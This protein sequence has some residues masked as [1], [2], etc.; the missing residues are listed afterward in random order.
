MPDPFD[1]QKK[2]PPPI[3]IPPLLRDNPAAHAHRP[4]IGRQQD[5]QSRY[6]T[7]PRNAS[8]STQRGLRSVSSP[9]TLSLEHDGS[10]LP[11]SGSQK[12]RT[13][14]IAALNGLLD[15]ARGSP[16]KSD[17]SST[18]RSKQSAPSHLGGQSAQAHP[19]T[20]V[21]DEWTSRAKIESRSERNL[22]KMTGQ[23]PPTPIANS[24]GPGEVFIL[25]EDLREQCRA[26]SGERK[27][28]NKDP[29]KSPKKKLF[30]MHMPTFG[31]TSS[32]APPMPSK[33]AQVFGQEPRNPTKHEVRPIKPSTYKTPTRAP[34]SD[35][36]KSLPAKVLNQDVYTRSHH[37]GAARRNRAAGRRSPPRD[38]RQS[39]DV[40]NS[41]PRRLDAQVSFESR[42]PPTPPAKDTPPD[43]K[44]LAQPTSPLRR[45]APSRH[46]REGYDATADAGKQLQFPAFA[47]SPSPT[48]SRESGIEG[49]SPT[50]YLPRTANEY[51]NL[52][53]GLPLPWD[54]TKEDGAKP[55]QKYAFGFQD[56][57]GQTLQQHPPRFDSL[58][59]KKIYGIR[60]EP[61]E[62][63]DVPLDF[64]A[65]GTMPLPRPVQSDDQ[66]HGY[67][68][69]E[70]WDHDALLQPRFYSPSN[71]SVQT[72][73]EGETP[74]KNSDTSRLLCTIASRADLFHH[75]QNSSNGSIHVTFQGNAD[76]VEPKST[77]G[78]LIR[79]RD[80]ESMMVQVRDD[81]GLAARVRQELR[82]GEQQEEAPRQNVSSGLLQ[83]EPSSSRLTDM[84]NGVS[85]RR[86]SLTGNF[87]PNCPSAVPS[88][89]H[90]MPAP[91]T[92]MLPGLLSGGLSSTPYRPKT[93]DD[94]FFMTNEHLDVVGK[95]HWDQL[96]AVKKSLL[97][98]SSHKH[99][100]LVATLEKKIKD[101]KMQVDSVKEKA[102][103]ATEQ[104]H[105]ILTKLDQLFEFV[106]EDVMG[107]LAAQEKKTA[108]ME[109]NVKELQTSV[110]NMQ[111]MQEQKR[112]ES[113]IGQQ[114][115]SGT[116]VAS[117]SL[118]NTAFLLAE[119]RSQASLAG[120]YGN[121]AESGREGMP[122]MPD[123]RGNGSAHDTHMDGRAPYGSSY[124]Q[125]QWALRH[126][127][128]GRGIKEDRPYS[129][130]NPYH[131]V[132]G[133]GN[134]NGYSGGFAAYSQQPE[135]HYGLHSTPA[136]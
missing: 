70:N 12:S 8:S 26:V 128:T 68:G 118:A 17:T 55:V 84:L 64:G 29:P 10:Q 35:T 57:H 14:A 114:Q 130:S 66:Q 65:V 51:Q 38:S 103:R 43:V 39:S 73:A 133:A 49:R 93:I 74:S 2:R 89:L 109:M 67:G 115:R 92:P 21:N 82:L 85:P 23:I 3:Y 7:A 123:E 50:K 124:G 117:S 47:L 69:R 25:R 36:V 127:Y 81:A 97:E 30:G 104:G 1:D 101:V 86:D 18:T 122:Q 95:S 62:N 121:I 59:G 125:Q 136:K 107:A 131:F 79:S 13:S 116:P 34:H 129:A 58:G 40:E 113:R 108:S 134:G 96:E 20:L 80:S 44:G 78:D 135:Q 9:L 31:R 120:F 22:F 112:Q 56:D 16:R 71:R 111:K 88:P 45:T 6:Q 61:E 11:K 32:P 27:V 94:H 19:D 102:D 99:G 48:K 90:K 91:I 46:L 4:S 87:D 42:H 5:S 60:E 15:Q 98:S 54:S 53:A 28:E 126:G 52:I 76:D 119:D 100:Q 110:L 132:H 77:T 75:R 63:Y 83:P 24:I 72:F 106:K 33:A 37:T 105:N 41:P